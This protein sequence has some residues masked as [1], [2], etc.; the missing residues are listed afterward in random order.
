MAPPGSGRRASSSSVRARTGSSLRIA[1]AN[2]RLGAVLIAAGL[3][4]SLEYIEPAG[5]LV[6]LVRGGQQASQRHQQ[7]R[8]C[9]RP[10]QGWRRA[11]SAQYRAATGSRLTMSPSS[12]R[13][14]STCVAKGWPSSAALCRARAGLGARDQLRLVEIAAIPG[15]MMFVELSNKQRHC[16]ALRPRAAWQRLRSCAHRGRSRA[17]RD[18]ETPCSPARPLT[19]SCSSRR[20]GPSGGAWPRW[21]DIFL[22]FF[23]QAPAQ[24][25]GVLRGQRRF[26]L[27]RF[28][29]LRC[30]SALP[31]EA[32][33]QPRGQ[34]RA[35]RSTVTIVRI[36]GGGLSFAGI[37]EGV[38]MIVPDAALRLGRPHRICRA[39]RVNRSIRKAR[40]RTG[41]SLRGTGRAGW[42]WTK[43]DPKA[44]VKDKRFQ[45][46]AS[47]RFA[48]HHRS[49]FDGRAAMRWYVSIGICACRGRARRRRCGEFCCAEPCE[50]AGPPA[51]RR[52]PSTGRQGSQSDRRRR[53]RACRRRL[54]FD[55]HG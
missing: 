7:A 31:S 50:P 49:Q 29:R 43:P 23:E 53:T 46:F 45:R 22:R 30:R 36:N 42:L 17:T 11:R 44:N 24:L 2:S 40:V 48:C 34:R 32:T 13:R 55:G 10:L 28:S 21:S 9:S 20:A 19:P 52:Q 16:L 5:A 38:T 33:M 4:E 14:A 18:L 3:A 12:S 26:W 54:L 6:R 8:L 27:G 15:T 25:D 39:G 35:G 47:A 51:E 37:F 41:Q 1:S